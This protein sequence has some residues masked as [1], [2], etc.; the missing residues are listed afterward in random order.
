MGD[1]GRF[2]TIQKEKVGYMRESMKP[3]AM[4]GWGVTEMQLSGVTHAL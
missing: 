1:L 4:M 3:P 2:E